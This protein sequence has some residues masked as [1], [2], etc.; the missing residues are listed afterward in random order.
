MFRI[1]FIPLQWM[2]GVVLIGTVF[3]FLSSMVA[4]RRHLEAV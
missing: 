3:G 2:I 1:E 4:V